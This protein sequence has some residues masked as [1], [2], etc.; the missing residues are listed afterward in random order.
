[1]D[2]LLPLSADELRARAACKI[3]KPKALYL[4]AGEKRKSC[5]AFYLRKKG[6]EVTEIDILRSKSHDLSIP[7]YSAKVLAR[8][9]AGEFEA[10]LVSPPCDT[11]TRV[12]FAN[13]YGPA[14]TRSFLEPLGFKNLSGN[15]LRS[16]KLGTLLMKFAL[17]A[18]RL[19]VLTSPGLVVAEFPEDLGVVMHGKW[20]GIRPASMW[21]FDEFWA[22]L[23]VPSVHT[24]GLRQHDFGTAYIKPTRLLLKGKLN[25]DDPKIFVGPPVFSHDGRYLGPIPKSESSG[26]Q[27]LARGPTE[28][29]FRTTGTAAWPPLLS[30]W[31]A[32]FL[33]VSLLDVGLRRG[34]VP[35]EAVDET[36]SFPCLH[37]ASWLLD[38]RLWPS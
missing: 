30:S 34:A 6:W 13:S 8:I 20:R 12:K 37:P 18:L 21:Q 5:V 11:Y 9:K 29:N 3:R 19:Q 16:T 23:N 2:P 15:R 35:A 17:E 36:K 25:L 14:P 33:H 26:L 1:M 28:K 4:F 24:V 38:R 32:D 31:S 22:L 27:T 7:A 10:I